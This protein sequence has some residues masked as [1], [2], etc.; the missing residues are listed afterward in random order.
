MQF[1]TKSKNRTALLR[2]FFSNPEERFYIRQLARIIET[3]AGNTQKELKKLEAE[4]ILKSI[5]IANLRYY[6]V[7]KEFPLLD[8]FKSMVSKT[9]GIESEI[10]KV[11]EN[12]SKIKFAFIFGSYAKGELKIKSDIDIFLIG[13]IGEDRVIKK[14]KSAEKKI[15]REINFHIA[16]QNEF[17]K[18]L[19]EKFFY[20]DIIKKYKLLTNNK[21]EFKRF[22]NKAGKSG[23][24]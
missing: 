22:I 3:S 20:K 5:K 13:N 23:K 1:L 11:F 14:I 10:K 12:E 24:A 8:E 21:D 17:L 7:N 16:K 6:S 2:I 4:G 18:S 19:K 15:G 9:I